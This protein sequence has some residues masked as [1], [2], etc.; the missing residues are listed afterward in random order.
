MYKL[1]HDVSDHDVNDHDVN[2][3]NANEH[4]NDLRL[5]IKLTDMYLASFP[6]PAQLSVTFSTVRKAG[7]G[8]GTRLHVPMNSD[9]ILAS[10]LW[11]ETFYNTSGSKN[12]TGI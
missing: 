5:M 12:G 7:R 10:G 6:G 9:F 1:E 2:D 3:D 11:N 8:L 4:V